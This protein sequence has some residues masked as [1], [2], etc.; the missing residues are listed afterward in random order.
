MVG[1]NEP[2]PCG[3][4]K[5]YKKCCLRKD[6]EAER[7]QGEAER[8]AAAVMPALPPLPVRPPAPLEPEP[9]PLDPHVAALDARWE[10]FDAEKDY[11]GQIA[12]IQ[13]SLDDGLLDDET[14]F[15]M[16]NVIYYHSVEH[17]GRDRFDALVATLRERLPDVFASDAHY[18]LDWLLTNALVAGR[19]A[20]IPALAREMGLTAGAHIDAFENTVEMLAY[21]G[22][23]AALVEMMALAWPQV[24]GSG[25][26]LPWG[27]DEFT[28]RAVSYVIFDY[29]EHTSTPDAGD[30]ELLAAIAP[31]ATADPQ[32]LARYLAHLL[33]QADQHWTMHDFKIEPHRGS[34]NRF[35]DEDEGDGRQDEGRE[36]LY[37]LSVE[38]LGYLQREEGVPYTK[39]ELARSNLLTYI[40]ARHDGELQPDDRPFNGRRPSDKR[41]PKP[42]A[43]QNS[44]LCPDRAT[45]DRFLVRFM[46]FFNLQRY[47]VAATFEFVPAWLRFLESRGLVGAEQRTQTLLELRELAADLRKAWEKYTADPSLR[48]EIER[49]GHQ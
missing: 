34:R 48:L 2:C 46:S 14:A 43:A 28:S 31:Y 37:H 23:L 21:H 45:L 40:L 15:E 18:Y 10:E 1:R 11:E 19:L 22:Q 4:G 39:G 6:L 12:I 33:G 36:N 3:S 17:D 16:F 7:L 25:D 49:W 24:R 47:P 44:L 27:V 42:S 20:D 9:E 8:A 26:I 30:P 38:F 13:Q 41:K 32:R 29:L 5:K 35:D